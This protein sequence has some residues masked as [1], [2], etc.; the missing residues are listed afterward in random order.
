MATLAGQKV[1]DAYSSLLKLESGAATSTTKIIEDGAGNDTA[2][3]LSTTKVE[4][5][6]QL[7]FTSSPS[8][9][10]TE[11]S[12]LF[13]DASNNI[14][15]RTLGAGAFTAGD[16]LTATAPIDITSDV[17]SLDAPTTLSQITSGTAATADSF[18]IYDASATA[19]KYI[20][21]DDLKTYVTTGV[22][23]TAAGADTEIQFNDGGVLGASSL[24]TYSDTQIYYAGRYWVVR[25]QSSGNASTYMAS[26]SYDISNGTTNGTWFV[27]EYANFKGLVV[28]YVAYNASESRKRMGRLSV[29]WDSSTGG[30]APVYAD[31]EYIALGTSTTS[32]LTFSAS[33][34]GSNLVV[35]ATNSVGE[36][37]YLRGSVKQ[38]YSY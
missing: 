23:A 20:T 16:A 3:K 4:V 25:E 18:F 32:A 14:V 24:F 13:L 7:A 2:L 33:I 12:A 15:K 36:T 8:T 28:E 30:T 9:G 10:S 38:F 22:V 31:E 26:E 35:S 17:V 6:G 21:L 19:H 34:V 29:L 11:T 1:K 37:M 27:C 5:N